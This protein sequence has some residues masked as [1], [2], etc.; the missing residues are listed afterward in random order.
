MLRAAEYASF[1]SKSWDTVGSSLATS[2]PF[3]EIIDVTSLP[4]PLLLN[5]LFL[6]HLTAP[7]VLAFFWYSYQPSGKRHYETNDRTPTGVNQL[8]VPISK[9][10]SDPLE[11]SLVLWLF[12]CL[13]KCTVSHWAQLNFQA[14]VAVIAAV[15]TYRFRQLSWS[16]VFKQIKQNWQLCGW[17]K[18]VEVWGEFCGI[19]TPEFGLWDSICEVEVVV[20]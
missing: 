2:Q 7:T 3:R 17:M 12:L 15:L 13:E 5:A 8:L 20:N 11:I 14:L 9:H 10:C 18:S 4:F 19:Q 1:G 16:T 6:V